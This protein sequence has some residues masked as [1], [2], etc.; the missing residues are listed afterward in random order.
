MPKV[1]SY[2]RFSSAK[3]AA[4]TSVAR[5]AEYA[6][7]WA[8]D[9]D[10]EL[11]ESLSMRDEGLS[12]YSQDHLKSGALG[13][14]MAAINAGRIPTGS[15]LVVEGLDRLSRAA[16]MQAQAQLQNI[17]SAGVEVVTASDGKRYSSKSLAENPMDI[18]Y[19]V[20]VMIRAHEE[21][22][23]K[24]KRVIAS[25]R[26][27]C[28]E[29]LAGT[30]RGRIVRGHDPKWVHWNGNSFELIPERVAALRL[31]ISRYLDGHGWVVISR[32][33]EKSGLVLTGKKAKAYMYSL[34]R[35]PALIGTRIQTAGG[36][37]FALEGYYP[38][39]LG[40]EEYARLQL[41]LERRSATTRAGGGKGIHPGLFTGIGVCK[42]GKCGEN[43][44]SQNKY[45]KIKSTG[46]S[47]LDRKLRCSRC[48][49][50]GK[51]ERGGRASV[52]AFPVEKALLDYCADQINL[53]SLVPD[54]DALTAELQ[55]KKADLVSKLADTEAKAARLVDAMLETSAA[56]A[57]L[58]KKSRELESEMS[59]L[60]DEISVVDARL[61][62]SSQ[63]VDPDISKKWNELRHAV[64]QLDYN[65]RI[66]CRQLVADTFDKVLIYFDGAFASTPKN[67]VDLLLIA[68]GG[69]RR[70]LSVDRKTGVLLR[71]LERPTQISAAGNPGSTG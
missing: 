3:Q 32:E 22:A 29:W 2:M 69:V 28:E 5:Q 21:S 13:V 48:Y 50:T 49:D 51:K 58:V 8:A 7:R 23:T 56:P 38:P 39:V 16:P 52:S 9:N 17:I 54:G 70:Y 53:R 61:T 11:D 40:K 64:L 10:M 15:V 19:A 12:A 27:R 1:Y 41:E 35:N 33:L 4:G 14:F 37:E 44:V 18:I 65:A 31:A 42:C 6:K 71:G 24:S 46:E 60:R 43:V 26:K 57:L 30:F 63:K 36:E 55:L 67:A 59:K 20:L 66:K 47:V 34:L 25:T 62:V 68:K 45:R